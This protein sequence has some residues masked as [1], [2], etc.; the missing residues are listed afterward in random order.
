[1][2]G[3]AVKR[4]NVAAA[5]M[6]VDV[7]EDAG[8]S[9]V[10]RLVEKDQKLRERRA[11]LRKMKPWQRRKYERD[12]RRAKLTV[13]LPQP[14]SSL[15]DEIAKHEIVS[16]S[17]AA[18]WLIATGLKLWSEGKALSPTITK[19]RNLRTE[20]SLAVSPEWSGERR[21]RTFDLPA[22]KKNVEALANEYG[23]GAS[24]VVAWL[25]SIGGSAYRSGG[26][27]QREASDSIRYPFRLKLPRVRDAV[28]EQENK[29]PADILRQFVEH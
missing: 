20:H 15:V 5:L 13:Y 7:P 18:S 1:M 10:D 11:K 23:C 17:S 9:E 22:F 29:S 2:A 26:M 21:K 14:L 12:K 25:M 8:T 3:D 16:P 4:V 6:G 24:D 27:P 19:S 28:G